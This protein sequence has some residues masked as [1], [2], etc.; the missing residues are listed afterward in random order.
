MPQNQSA[1]T[2]ASHS[3]EPSRRTVLAGA[4]WSMPIVATAATL[5]SAAASANCP[6]GTFT[7]QFTTGQGTGNPITLRATSPSTAEVFTVRITST[8]DAGTTVTQSNA[9]YNLTQLSSGWNGG[10]AN[11]GSQDYVFN[12]FGRRGALVLNQRKSGTTAASAPGTDGQQLRFD[13]FDSAGARIDPT[14]VQFDIFDISST[15][16]TPAWRATYWDAVGFSRAPSA[17]T[18]TPGKDAGVG[19]GTIR[20]PF[21]RSTGLL[22]TT[23]GPWSD[24][25]TFATFPSGSYMRYTQLGGRQGWHFI[26]VS[27]LRFDALVPC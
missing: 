12:D 24:Q 19:A 8:L 1:L 21:G 23:A 5:P 4:A 15:D 18:T 7:V 26:S 22:P 10:Y 27:G 9:N 11:D 14:N 17:I 16:S 3:I 6:T 25:F 13:F 2:T 20:S